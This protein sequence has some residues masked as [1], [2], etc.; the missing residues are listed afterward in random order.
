M[1]AG[2]ELEAGAGDAAVSWWSAWRLLII[3]G[4]AVVIM[5]IIILI[6]LASGT[7]VAGPQGFER[8]IVETCRR[9]RDE[10]G[11]SGVQPS[12]LR[13]P[14]FGRADDT[15]RMFDFLRR[16][17]AGV[18]ERTGYIAR[19]RNLARKCAEGYLNQREA[20][21]HPLLGK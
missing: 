4:V 11:P 20:M 10:F 9:L 19:I 17:E 2:T 16:E 8:R 18:T 6:M 14:V 12:A 21:G 13:R 15:A 7:E 1:D 5:A 3:G